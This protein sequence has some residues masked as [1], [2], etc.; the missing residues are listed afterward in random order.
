MT[1]RKE[2]VKILTGINRFSYKQWEQRK[3]AY[4]IDTIYI[5]VYLSN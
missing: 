3:T 4:Y 5:Y 2:F 1:E